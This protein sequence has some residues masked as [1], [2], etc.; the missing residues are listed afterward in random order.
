MMKRARMLI[1]KHKNNLEQM[2]DFKKRQDE[3]NLYQ[4]E[5]YCVPS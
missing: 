1:D 2:E 3:N 5:K 4:D